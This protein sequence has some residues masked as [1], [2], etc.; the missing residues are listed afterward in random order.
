VRATSHQSW[1][2][3]IIG[4]GSAGLASAAELRTAG[5]SV[6]VL[7][8]GDRVGENWHRRYPS[9][10]LNTLRSLSSLPGTRI[11]RPHGNWVPGTSF[12]RYL[13]KYA[14]DHGLEVRTRTR[15]TGIEP[16]DDAGWIVQTPEEEIACDVVVVATGNAAIPVIPE[17]PHR[18][19]FTAPNSHSDEYQQPSPY[20]GRRV[21]VVGSGNSATEIATELAG[22][23][24]HVWMSVRT[25]PLLV[26][27]RSAGVATH[28]ISV[29]GARLPDSVWDTLSL[30]SH[31]SLYRNLTKFGLGQPALGSHA[32]FRRDWVAP[33]AERGFAKAVRRG[34]IEIVPATE[35]LDGPEAIL[36]GGRRLVPDAV[37]AATGYRPAFAELVGHL[38]ILRSDGRP[39]AWAASL[40]HAPGLFMV[41]APSLQGDLREHGREA[42]RVVAAVRELAAGR[43][44]HR[45]ASVPVECDAS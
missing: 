32:R 21:L 42:R 30:A 9:L 45:A 29:L 25:S 36:A 43:A 22:T 1:R 2:A 12:A 15:A 10:R 19:S 40:R 35:D 39:A 31:R 6:V 23:A 3:V 14:V 18:E 28:R 27:P 13:E 38:D 34:L 41:G 33:I 20:A 26:P 5:L 37:I 7:E 11:P 24:E 17:W 8:G 16:H 44:E 4:A